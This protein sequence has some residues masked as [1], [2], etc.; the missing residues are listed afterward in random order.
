M[1]ICLAAGTQWVQEPPHAKATG[2]QPKPPRV[3]RILFSQSSGMCYGYCYSGLEIEPGEATLLIQSRQEDRD[4][5]PDLKV[6]ADLSDKHWKELVQLV[7]RETLL[8]LPERIGCP[9]CVD[10][11]IESLEVR[12]SNHTKKIVRYNFGSGPNEI[13]SLSARVAALL[14][15]LDRELPLTTRRCGR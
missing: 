6:S 2:Q 5:C 13:Q 7:D 4:K 15:K 8:A 11:V 9:G 1:L 3:T 10:E 14:D 12:F